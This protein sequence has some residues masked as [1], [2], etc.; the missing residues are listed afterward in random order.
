MFAARKYQAQFF[1][2]NL[3]NRLEFSRLKEAG[4]STII[5]RVYN[6]EEVGGGLYFKNSQF[7]VLEP[8]LDS[9]ISDA[10]KSG[11]D[12][13][14]WMMTR[15]F[16]WISD[17]RL[18]DYQYENDLRQMIRKLDVFNP[19][20]VQRLVTVFRELASHKIDSI[21]I[22]DDLTL[23]FNEGFSNWGKAKFT[24]VTGV[25][26]KEKLMMSKN[27]PYNQ[28]WTRV[29]MNQLNKVL[30]LITE[31]CKRVNS[32][33]KVGINVYYE[34]PIFTQRSES[35]YG[36]NL[37]ELLATGV[38]HIYLMTYQRQIKSELKKSEAAN[39]ELFRKIVDNAYAVCKEKLIVKVQVRDWQTGERVP[40]EEIRAY[41]ALIPPQVKQVCFTPVKV[42]D[43]DYLKQIIAAE[44]NK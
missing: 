11:L 39:R 38:D 23:R 15:K 37:G 41:L 8:T 32:S 43:Y 21:L 30:K 28:N 1:A 29:K 2:V 9:V 16:K 3:H 31:A 27:T 4:I 40:M 34:T 22:Q 10:S 7:H 36:H 6:D 25:P 33:V 42:G 35:W 14:A 44:A 5:Y 20:V 24:G 19:D 17:S 12:V 13:C 18:L 26:A